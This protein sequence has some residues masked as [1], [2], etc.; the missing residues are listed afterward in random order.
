MP[1]NAIARTLDDSYETILFDSELDDEGFYWRETGLIDRYV[2]SITSRLEKST[3]NKVA[4]VKVGELFGF[5]VV[6]EIAKKIQK[7]FP[8][9]EF[10][11]LVDDNREFNT[12]FIHI[13]PFPPWHISLHHA[14]EYDGGFDKSDTKTFKGINNNFNRN[15]LFITRNNRPKSHR[16]EWVSFL[17]KNNLKDKGYVSEGWNGIYLEGMR[18]P[19]PDT[20]EFWDMTRNDVGLID[21]YNDVFCEVALSSDYDIK[22]SPFGAYTSDKEFRPFLCCVI[23]LIVVFKNYD[24][25]LKDVGFDM[26]DDVIDTSFYKTDDLDRKFNIIK[27]N[28]KIIEN[29]L[30]VDGRFRDDIWVRLKKNQ[31]RFFEGW[32]NYFYSKMEE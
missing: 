5:L 14:Y 11:L 18:D 22:E 29:D 6:E 1:H 32:G 17:E 8:S 16:L 2:E 30:T 21:F 27:S 19:E 12:E 31:N 28:F 10:I 13:K 23:P 7:I 25:C 4:F 15:K 3:K 20:E 24:E 26:F 9:K